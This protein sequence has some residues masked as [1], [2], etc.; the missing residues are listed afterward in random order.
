MPKV[1]IEITDPIPL[2]RTVHS[3]EL[4]ENY[5][6]EVG[7]TFEGETINVG[8]SE[9]AIVT[10]NIVNVD[11]GIVVE[12][13]ST[14]PISASNT[15]GINVGKNANYELPPGDNLIE[16]IIERLELGSNRKMTPVSPLILSVTPSVLDNAHVNAES[17]GNVSDAVRELN[18]ASGTFNSLSERLDADEER[19]NTAE[20]TL[21]SK[22]D[23]SEELQEFFE[24]TRD[25]LE[26]YQSTDYIILSDLGTI[27]NTTPLNSALNNKTIYNFVVAAGA[28]QTFGVES[29]TSCQMVF[30]GDYQVVTFPTL[31]KKVSRLITSYS[32]FNADAWVII[33]DV[34]DINAA[35]ESIMNGGT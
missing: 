3:H 1:I 15:V 32:P 10:A 27:Q 7:F 21:E 9:A 30:I 19:L 13:T 14:G 28:A 11:R 4:N 34:G 26:E 33:D 12:N 23:N 8:D 16:F 31:S 17:I 22:L 24:Q 20:T 6:I 35:L 2:H 25:M 29:G 5:F 18:N